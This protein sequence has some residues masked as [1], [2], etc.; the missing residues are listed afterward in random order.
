MNTS[1]HFGGEFKY[2]ITE[3]TSSSCFSFNCT[4]SKHP[5]PP[6]LVVDNFFAPSTKNFFK[7]YFQV[8][9]L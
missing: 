2:S 3:L 8:F 1:S 6:T 4:A 9:G 7:F 5:T